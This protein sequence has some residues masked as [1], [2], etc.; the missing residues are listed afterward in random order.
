MKDAKIV[1]TDMIEDMQK[2]LKSNN[3]SVCH[4][5][6]NDLV[7]VVCRLEL[8]DEVFISEVLESIFYNLAETH[9]YAI[10]KKVTD[11]INLDISEKIQCLVEAYNTKDPN[12]LY[13]SLKQLR[14][15]TTQ[16]QLNVWQ[17]YDVPSKI[18]QPMLTQSGG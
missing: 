3:Y 16:H 10:P 12:Q 4:K 17:N 8:K 5:I 13:E 1:F 2:N 18:P 14:Y 7:N 11:K 6:S 9:S 15:I